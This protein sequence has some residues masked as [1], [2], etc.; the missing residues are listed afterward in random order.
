[1]SDYFAALVTRTLRPETGVQP[2]PRAPFEEIEA[3]TVE[4]RPVAAREVR[5]DRERMTGPPTERAHPPRSP[6]PDA[7]SHAAPV[8]PAARS[9]PSPDRPARAERNVQE[10]ARAVEPHPTVRAVEPASEPTPVSS[11]AVPGA[12]S[13][14]RETQA[15]IDPRAVPPA[16]RP[17]VRVVGAPSS[18]P[19]VHIHIG[20][21]DVRAV[22][23]NP[24]AKAG[25]REPRRE[26][27]TL[28]EYLRRR[29][30]GRS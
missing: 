9:Q 3:P 25:P 17:E 30:D 8:E 4:E 21:V 27:A 13:A 5:R 15:R 26:P 18:E 10:A 11:A 24:P 20:R 2:R 6:L 12:R 14:V 7:V 23:P 1:M 29:R 16:R 28:D 19:T 22:A